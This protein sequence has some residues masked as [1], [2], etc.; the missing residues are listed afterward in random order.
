[1]F[2]YSSESIIMNGGNS[3]DKKVLIL[4]QDGF[5]PALYQLSTIQLCTS[6]CIVP[7]YALCQL[8]HFILPSNDNFSENCVTIY[9]EWLI[10]KENGNCVPTKGIVRLH[11]TTYTLS[12]IVSWYFCVSYFYYTLLILMLQTNI[13]FKGRMILWW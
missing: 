1:M 3:R 7:A 10:K 11:N 8:T 4:G 6:L 5:V 9:N 13:S 2:I 12:L